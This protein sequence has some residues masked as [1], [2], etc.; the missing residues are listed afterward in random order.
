MAKKKAIPRFGWSPNPRAVNE[1]LSQLRNP[2]FGPCAYQ[3]KGSGA[4]KVALLWKYVERFTGNYNVRAQAIGDCVSFGVAAAVDA[5]KATEI[6]VNGDLEEWVA[7][8]ATEPIYAASRVEIGR[9]EL[10]TSDGSYGAWG[11][12]AAK[13]IGTLVRIQYPN[14]DLRRYSGQRAKQWGNPGKGVPDDLE[15][16]M[17]EHPIRTVSLVTTYEEVRDA[18]SNGYA[19]TIASACGFMTTRDREGFLKPSGKWPHQMA[20]IGVDDDYRRPG[21]LV[22]NSWGRHWVDG[23]KRHDQPDGTFWCDADVLEQK[24]LREQDSWVFGDYEGFPPKKLDLR[25]I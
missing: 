3:I 24:I 16:T 7:E 13:E 8:T 20:I 23:P 5:V 17:R 18:I 22:V 19:V 25:I 15:L 14:C 12:R 21:V 2:V 11:A 6:C 1:V 9:G 10:G 4:G